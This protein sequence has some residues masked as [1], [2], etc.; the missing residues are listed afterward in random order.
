MAN[1]E[2]VG[3]WP[4]P[5]CLVT[6][7]IGKRGDYAS[8]LGSKRL[9][10]EVYDFITKWMQVDRFGDFTR[11][12]KDHYDLLHNGFIAMTRAVVNLR[13]LLYQRR[14]LRGR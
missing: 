12:S 7:T 13:T 6:I 11:R 2:S 8:A 1:D 10:E 4:S 14:E 9:F 5:Q 3:L